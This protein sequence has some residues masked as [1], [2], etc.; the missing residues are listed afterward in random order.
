[1][2]REQGPRRFQ[3]GQSCRTK[4]FV[5]RICGFRDHDLHATRQTMR[6]TLGDCM[7]G[8]I[9]FDTVDGACPPRAGRAGMAACVRPMVLGV[10]LPY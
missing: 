9:D 3:C 6:Q 4:G 8:V 5:V 1:M 7:G 10:M 2:R